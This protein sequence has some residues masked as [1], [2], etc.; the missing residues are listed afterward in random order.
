MTFKSLAAGYKP[1]NSKMSYIKIIKRRP[2]AMTIDQV[3][4]FFMKDVIVIRHYSSFNS[5]LLNV[6]NVPSIIT[7]GA[8][9]Y[10]RRERVK[11]YIMTS[12]HEVC[13]NS[14]Y[15]SSKSLRHKSCFNIFCSWNVNVN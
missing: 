11:R 2:L 4:F 5:F 6:A 14:F 1:D 9:R 12:K 15:F 8:F 10:I 3:E 7:E 13:Y